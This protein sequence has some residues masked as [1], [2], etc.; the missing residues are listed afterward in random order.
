[1]KSTVLFVLLGAAIA[2]SIYFT[3]QR[4][5][6]W[7]NFEVIYSEEEEVL[8]EETAGP[9]APDEM[10]AEPQDESELVE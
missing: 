5:F 9:D 3:Y 2:L 7:Q 4:S 8:E 1:M 6:V 10:E